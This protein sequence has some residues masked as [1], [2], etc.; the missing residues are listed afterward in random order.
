MTVPPK[1][2]GPNETVAVTA[3]EPSEVATADPST[4]P[5]AIL[6][7]WNEV[8]FGID[9]K[10]TGELYHYI[11]LYLDFEITNNISIYSC[12]EK[13]SGFS[14]ACK[15]IYA[16]FHRGN[17][18]YPR[19]HEKSASNSTRTNPTKDWRDGKRLRARKSASRT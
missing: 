9:K 15:N 1:E 3:E 8:A 10:S 13:C 12:L 17:I 19:V 11:L 2:V 6:K 16:L 14:H 4:P 18:I 7:L 5:E